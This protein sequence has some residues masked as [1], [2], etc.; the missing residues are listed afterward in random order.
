MF[1]RIGGPQAILHFINALNN[2]NNVCAF[3]VCSS[4]WRPAMEWEY[5]GLIQQS[6]LFLTWLPSSPGLFSDAHFCF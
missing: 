3:V 2:N 1:D 5:W 6:G 4:V